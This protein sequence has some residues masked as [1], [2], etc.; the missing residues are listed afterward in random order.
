ML[1]RAAATAGPARA[2]DAPTATV[3]LTLDEA[4]ARAVEASHRL[5][6]ARARETVAQAA[7]AAR[8]AAERPPVSASAGYPRTNHVLEFTVPSPTGVPRVHYPDV[9]YK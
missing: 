9:P 1:A 8:Q 3:R 2:Q 4:R 7:I 5:A 6:E